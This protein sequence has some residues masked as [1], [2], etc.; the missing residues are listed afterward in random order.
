M[1]PI[2]VLF[3]LLQR[4]ETLLN[5]SSVVAHELEEVT[6]KIDHELDAREAEASMHGEHPADPAIRHQ[7]SSDAPEQAWWV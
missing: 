2:Q 6:R 7:I 3:G 5:E 1:S 4:R